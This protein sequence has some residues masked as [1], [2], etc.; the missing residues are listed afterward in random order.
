MTG[1]KRADIRPGVKV[2]VVQKQHQRSGQ[3][4]EGTVSQLLTKSAT[5]PHGIKVRLTDGTV[6]RVK[7]VLT[8]PE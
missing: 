5:H 4:T 3:L 8:E 6:G 7:E 2:R 1:S